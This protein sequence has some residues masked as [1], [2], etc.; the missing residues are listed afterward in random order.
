M[1]AT[2]ALVGGFTPIGRP[3]PEELARPLAANAQVG[4]GQFVT[5]DSNGRGALNDG[6]VPNLVCIG[7]GDI[8]E[9]SDSSATAGA[10]FARVSQ[11][12]F[13]GNAMGTS[14]DAFTD[15]DI[16]V[17]FYIKDEN[18]LGKLSNLSGSNRSLGGL[19][20]GIKT[21]DGT[22]YAWTG[23][24][25]WLMARATLLT[26]NEAGL[27]QKVVDAAAGTAT[28]ESIIPRKAIHGLVTAIIITPAAALTADAT[29][30]ATLTVRK[31]DGAGGAAV[32]LGTLVTDVA[33]GNWVAF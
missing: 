4:K 25:A 16:G 32:S 10:A 31:R 19:V 18:T 6:T 23:V 14:T 24:V 5:V 13:Y 20:F 21:Q 26:D 28:A 7:Q 1:T 3:L 9:L 33:G 11:R 30:N 8:S 2:P 27:W 22:P 12:W 17:P 29:N 15:S